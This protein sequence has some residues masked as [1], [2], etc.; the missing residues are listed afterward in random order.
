MVLPVLPRAQE[1]QARIK[2]QWS[3][4]THHNRKS[5][6]NELVRSRILILEQVPPRSKLE[7]PN[8]ESGYQFV[9]NSD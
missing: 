1:N 8:K 5:D 6:F 9:K 7:F 4:C 3:L 2:T